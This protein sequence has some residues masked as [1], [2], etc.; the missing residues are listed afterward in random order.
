MP[1]VFVADIVRSRPSAHDE[2]SEASANVF[3]EVPRI[4][5]V[6]EGIDAKWTAFVGGFGIREE[7]R[8]RLCNDDF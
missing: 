6:H 2:P 4:E 7:A 1:G 5:S 8:G 3:D